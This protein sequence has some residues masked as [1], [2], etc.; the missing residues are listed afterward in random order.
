MARSKKEPLENEF[1][2]PAQ[3]AGQKIGILTGFS[4]G[5][6]HTKKFVQTLRAAGFEHTNDLQAADIIVAHSGGFVFLPKDVRA[7][8]IFVVNPPCEY[9]TP[10]SRVTLQKIREDYDVHRAIGKRRAFFWKNSWNMWYLVS[11]LPRQRKIVQVVVRDRMQL[12]K[13][14][15]P[16]VHIIVT[17]RDPWAGSITPATSKGGNHYSYLSLAGSHDDIW[18]HPEHYVAII[19]AYHES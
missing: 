9:P 7:K 14:T 11:Q 17:K 12:P 6:Y 19:K 13:I 2:K 8:R 15:A 4:E 10:A 1:V 3:P 16:S 18:M 5:K